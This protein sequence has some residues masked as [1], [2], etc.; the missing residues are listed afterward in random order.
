M[1]SI[2]D[3]DTVAGVP[4]ARQRAHELGLLFVDG[5]EL[6]ATLNGTTQGDPIHLLG[7][8]IDITH[9]SLLGIL[10][11][12]RDN[13]VE[14]TQEICRKLTMMGYPIPFDEVQSRCE[15]QS[16]SRVH[17]AQVMKQRG[18]V[19]SIDEAFLEYI[20]DDKPAYVSREGPTPEQLIELIHAAGGIAVWA[21]PY[22]SRRDGLIEPLLDAGLDGLECFHSQFDED[23]SSHYQEMAH[24]NDLIVTGGSDFHGTLEEEFEL[25]DWWFNLDRLPVE[26]SVAPKD[27]ASFETS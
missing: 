4:E 2:T 26:P 1:I 7:Y 17:I 21:H 13:R 8:G 6:E 10:Q 15:G 3:H 19:D 27:V 18:F 22:Y 24:E 9:P 14:R 5:I 11:Q 23:T 25:G 16:V 12:I 20:G